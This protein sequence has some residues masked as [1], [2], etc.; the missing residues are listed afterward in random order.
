[1]DLG[2]KARNLQ[3]DRKKRRRSCGERSNKRIQFRFPHE[4]CASISLPGV[5]S[6]LRVGGLFTIQQKGVFATKGGAKK[7][8]ITLEDLGFTEEN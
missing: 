3:Q 1:M 8:N 7:A 4:E 5:K 6:K 2:S